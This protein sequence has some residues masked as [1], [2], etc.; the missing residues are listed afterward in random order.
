MIAIILCL[1]LAAD[2]AVQLPEKVAAKPGRLVQI[3]A[4]SE[5]K[6][7][8]WFLIGEDAD[9]IVMESTKAA[10]FSATNPGTYRVLA[11]TAAGDVPSD[12]AVCAIQVGEPPAPTPPSP[13]PPAPPS[14][15]SPPSDPLQ[16]ALQGIY[17]GLEDPR[18]DEYRLALVGIYRQAAKTAND[19]QL[20]TA[21]ELYLVIRRAALKV[22]PDDALRPVRERLA[23]EIGSTLPTD[24]SAV[25]NDE[26]RKK[27]VN[28][29]TRMANLLEVIQ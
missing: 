20:K 28:C 29:Y 13:K 10:I 18:K 26:I 22:L 9:L 3:T 12:P 27:A 6:V 5:Q 1:L 19:A 7:V 16:A 8:K 2:P 14:P 25:L 24:S 4:K 23:Q 11:W 21:G 15:P 17:G